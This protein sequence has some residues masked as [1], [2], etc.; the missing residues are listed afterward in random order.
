VTV[1]RY[2]GRGRRSGV[3]IDGPFQFGVWS[4]RDGKVTRVD[5]YPTREEAFEAVGL[6]ES[7]HPA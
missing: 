2:R 7:N 5:W 1:S 3:E 6:K 4:I